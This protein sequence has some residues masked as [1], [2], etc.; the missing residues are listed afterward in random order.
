VRADDGFDGELI[1]LEDLLNLLDFIAGIEHQRF[2]RGR[3]AE[4]RTIALQPADGNDFV[5]QRPAGGVPAKRGAG[6]TVTAKGRFG[7]SEVYP[8]GPA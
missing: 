6:R 8:A 2:A 3:V 1:A 4:D 7:F 5:N